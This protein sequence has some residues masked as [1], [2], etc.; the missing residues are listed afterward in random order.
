MCLAVSYDN[1]FLPPL[2]IYNAKVGGTVSKEFTRA[3]LNYPAGQFYTV[4]E[5]AWTDQTVMN[6]WIKTV[7]LPNV[8]RIRDEY[9]LANTLALLNLDNFS[10]HGTADT[11]IFL[12]EHGIKVMKLPP[13]T[14]SKTQ[15]LGIFILT[16]M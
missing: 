13:N 14:T 9:G 1:E 2:I 11:N 4:Q 5:N 7:F 6:Y 3:A 12:T 10:V 16:L 15:V 8:D